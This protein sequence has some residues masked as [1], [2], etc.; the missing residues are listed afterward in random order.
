MSHKIKA[1]W[2]H[3][4]QFVATDSSGHSMV[5]DSPEM[6]EDT[7]FR[8]AQLLLFALAGCTAMDVIS[9]LRKKRQI[10]LDF[11]V[12]VT[13]ER[14]EEHPKAWTRMHVEYIVRGPD[15]DRQAVE[16]AVE[17]SETK[18]C[19]VHATLHGNVEMSSS[20]TIE[21]AENRD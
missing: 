9:I 21:Q 5:M 18:Y 16:R 6:G 4:W 1:R 15:I 10:V 14:R 2:L 11:E 12:V 8:P 17:L 3:G 13:G 19:S 7:G 20:I